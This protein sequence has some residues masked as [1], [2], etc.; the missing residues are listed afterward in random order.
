[1]AAAVGV[2]MFAPV[3]LANARINFDQRGGG[4]P[5]GV[6]ALYVG[7]TNAPDVGY[8]ALIL[9]PSGSVQIWQAD[10]QGNWRFLK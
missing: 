8:R 7:N 1:L 4:N 3:P 2:P 6:Y 9:L 5:G 10:G